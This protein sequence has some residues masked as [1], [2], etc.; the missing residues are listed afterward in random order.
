M[1]TSSVAAVSSTL[2]TICAAPFGL[3]CAALFALS[4]VRLGVSGALRG[5]FRVRPRRF[6]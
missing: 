6:S 3:A 4:A 1:A 5:V 2:K